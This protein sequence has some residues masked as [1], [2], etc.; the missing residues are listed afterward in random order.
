MSAPSGGGGILSPKSAALK[1]S[2]KAQ[3]DWERVVEAQ[4]LT[5]EKLSHEKKQILQDKAAMES[6]GLLIAVFALTCSALPLCGMHVFYFIKIFGW[7]NTSP[8]IALQP[9]TR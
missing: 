7:H 9:M 8:F 4:A 1:K 3:K 5:I 2:A 6:A